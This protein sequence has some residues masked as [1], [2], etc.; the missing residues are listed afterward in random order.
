MTDPSVFAV[1]PEGRRIW[2]VA[3]IF[4]EAERLA[5]L[6]AA[7]ESRIRDSD[8]LI[9]LGNLI[10]RGDVAATIDELLV[11][12]RRLMASRPGDA[13]G[14]IVYLRGSQEEIWHKLLQMQFAPN[15]SEVLEWM[16][17]Q[18]VEATLAAY[19]GRVDEGR[20]AARLGAVALSRWTNQLRA[21]MRAVDGHDQLMI[22]LRRAAYTS[23]NALL[24]VNAGVDPRRPLS[25]QRD[26]FWWGSREF[27]ASKGR[28]GDFRRVIRGADPR[29]A[30]VVLRDGMASLDGGCGFGGPLIAGC[31][32]AEGELVDVIEA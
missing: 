17:R 32:D 25:A 7:L 10:G 31:F 11:F 13:A 29:R 15:P 21:A 28:Y 6:H 2:A 12:R 9:Y 18:G 8:S 30:G 5:A 27:E 4:A 3:S 24:F 26:T 14:D 23:D 16:L 22:S 1:L 20:T 19:G